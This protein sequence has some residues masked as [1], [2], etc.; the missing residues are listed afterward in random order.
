[1]THPF[2]DHFSRIARGYAAFRPRYP[3][4]LFAWLARLPAARDLAWD[5][6]AGN[7]Q[8]SV[9]LAEHFHRVIATDASTGQLAS[10]PPHPGVVYRAAPAAA[11]GLADRSVDLVTVAQALHWLE[12]AAFYDEVR[13]VAR[14]GGA[15]AA[16]TYNL[17]ETGDATIDGTLRHFHDDVVGPWWPPERRHVEAGYRTLDFPFDEVP[18]PPFVMRAEWTL[19]DLVGY[20]GTW[21]ASV[22]YAEETGKDSV[23]GIAGALEAQWGSGT[24]AV[25]WPLAI[26]AGRI[27]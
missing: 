24:R 7:G 22:K 25:T 4:E 11:S 1:M 26:R 6:A 13:R 20:L 17:L 10:A 18:A 8:A 14:A 12:P 27:G 15:I 9:P 5:C 19:G 21:S 16:W 2:A 3:A 23:Q